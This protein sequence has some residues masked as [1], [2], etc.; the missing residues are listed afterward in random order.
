MSSDDTLVESVE[1]AEVKP[2]TVEQLINTLKQLGE[3]KMEIIDDSPNY[4]RLMIFKV[5][6]KKLQD[7]PLDQ[8]YFK[9]YHKK[10]SEDSAGSEDK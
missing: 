5:I 9:I 6:L 2:T 7:R 8:K 10:K 3:Y 1:V 4:Q